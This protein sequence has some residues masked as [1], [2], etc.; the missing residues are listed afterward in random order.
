MDIEK[1]IKFLKKNGYQYT[2]TREKNKKIEVYTSSSFRVDPNKKLEI[3][4]GGNV[5]IGS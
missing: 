4:S 2:I 3:T 1:I 5:G